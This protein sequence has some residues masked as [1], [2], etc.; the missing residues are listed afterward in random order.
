MVTSGKDNQRVA[1]TKRLLR[2]GLMRL[3]EKKPLQ[4]ISI[5]ELCQESGINRA[6]F[7]RHF[8]AP[9]D[10]LKDV[11]REMY[12][13]LRAGLKQPQSEKDFEAYFESICVYV[14]ENADVIRILLHNVT[15][16]EVL[17]SIKELNRVVINEYTN[18]S[19][20]SDLDR[21]SREL[22]ASYFGGGGYFL[23][24]EWITTGMKKTPGEIASLIWRFI[25]KD[26]YA[27]VVAARI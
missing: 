23:M 9:A 1:L 5:C 14:Y 27:A 3:L 15:D 13:S 4:K 20:L 7:Y 16:E 17:E 11:G 24:R 10:V 26:C 6:T 8:D 19:R 22:M 21:E 25:D 18:I 12:R 2:E